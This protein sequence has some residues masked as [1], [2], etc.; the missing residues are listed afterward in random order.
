M[1]RWGEGKWKHIP[2]IGEGGREAPLIAQVQ[3]TSKRGRVLLMTSP[4][5]YQYVSVES[6][7]L[8]RGTLSP[9]FQV[10]SHA[11]TQTD[12]YHNGSK[13]RSLSGFEFYLNE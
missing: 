7:R 2:K 9:D 13:H 10:G 1:G 11:H 12:G 4:N 6:G 8:L 5:S 3:L